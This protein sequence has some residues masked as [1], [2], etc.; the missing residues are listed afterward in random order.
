MQLEEIHIILKSQM[1]PLDAKRLIEAVIGLSSADIIAHPEKKISQEHIDQINVYMERRLKGEPL[2]KILGVKEFWGLEFITN[3]DV[4]DPRPDTETLVEAVLDWVRTDNVI[5]RSGGDEAIYQCQEGLPRS[6][7]S[8]AMTP[9][10][11][12]LDLGTGTGCIPISLLS[13]LPNATVVAVDMSEEALNVARQ[14]AEKHNVS[15][16]IEFIQSDWFDNI[17]GK[18]NIVTSNPPYIVDSEIPN[19][20]LEVKNHDPILAL[21]GGKN[22]LEAYKKIF[23]SL[24]NYLK[25]DGRAFFEIGQNQLFDIARLVDESNLLAGDS[26]LD[27]AGITRVVEISRGDK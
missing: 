26:R 9:P 2:S 3:E 13:E 17:E 18:F 27:I 11:K 6:V 19:L 10:L 5:A 4:L 14:N 1:D 16:R 21:S 25:S 7:P 12:I 20:A 22:G 15:D 8:P 24:K 23:F